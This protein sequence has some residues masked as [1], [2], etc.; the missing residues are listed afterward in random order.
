MKRL[1]VL[2]N[3]KLK[4]TEELEDGTTVT[5]NVYKGYLIGDIPNEYTAWFNYK[6]LTYILY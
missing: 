3:K 4:I 1:K 5:K 6:G 2:E